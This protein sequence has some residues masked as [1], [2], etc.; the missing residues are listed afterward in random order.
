VTLR[1]VLT[2]AATLGGVAI[3]LAQRAVSS[4]K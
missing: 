1:L 3:V 2:A 4:G